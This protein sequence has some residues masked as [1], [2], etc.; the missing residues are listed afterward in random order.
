MGKLG[1]AMNEIEAALR[2]DPD[3]APARQLLAQVKALPQQAA[4]GK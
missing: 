4:A 2:I 3:Y 1:H